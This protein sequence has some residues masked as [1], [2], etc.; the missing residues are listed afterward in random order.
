[1]VIQNYIIGN[2]VSRDLL[3]TRFCYIYKFNLYSNRSIHEKQ[4]ALVGWLAF[5]TYPVRLVKIDK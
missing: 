2:N 5:I 3:E 4:A 1:M